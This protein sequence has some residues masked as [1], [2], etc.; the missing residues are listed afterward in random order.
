MT[1]SLL[2]TA[3]IV[4]GAVFGVLLLLSEAGVRSGPAGAAPLL[5]VGLGV[6]VL[7]RYTLR[8][9][10]LDQLGRAATLICALPPTEPS[11]STAPALG[12]RIAGS[13]EVLRAEV[14]LANDHAA[15]STPPMPGMRRSIS[16]ASGL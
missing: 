15:A 13:A 9:L 4:V 1:D 6:A 2:I 5:V 14:A 7:L 8:L 10:T 11:S 12:E 16:T 3:G